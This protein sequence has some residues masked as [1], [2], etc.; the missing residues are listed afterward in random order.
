LRADSLQSRAYSFG[1]EIKIT[2]G[3]RVRRD[4]LRRRKRKEFTQRA[5]RK[6]TEFTE[7]RGRRP[8]PAPRL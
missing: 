8:G 1:G 7:K 3:R 4:S 6:S 2:Q 5:L